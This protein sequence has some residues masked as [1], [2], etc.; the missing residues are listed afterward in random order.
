MKKDISVVIL[1]SRG[2]R[3][4]FFCREI[5]KS[6]CVKGVVVDDR[7][8]FKDRLLT[9]FKTGGFNPFRILRRMYLKK[10]VLPYDRRDRETEERYFPVAGTGPEFPEGVPVRFSRDPNNR[11]TIDWIKALSPDVISVFGTRLIKEPVLSLARLGALNLHTGLSPFYRGGQCTFWAL[12]HG[13]VD[14]VGVTVHHLSRK[15]DGGDI[16]FTARPEIVPEDTVRSIECKLVELATRGMIDAIDR[17]GSGEKIGT[18]QGK[19]GRLF[20]SREF[21]LEKRL[22]F[23]KR[24]EKGWLFR[25]LE[26]RGR[27]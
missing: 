12:Y 20:L 13:D 4:S 5:A 17:I 21:T 11:E 25:L 15:I 22:E 8:H 23:E 10:L 1:T 2:P 19:G 18:A 3:H 24:M 16:V 14:H 9:F 27:N 26:E 6:F 7:Y